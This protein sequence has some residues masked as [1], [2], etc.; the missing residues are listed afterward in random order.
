M[1][2][3]AAEPVIADV[4]M[5]DVEVAE[6]APA[7]EEEAEPK[8]A[9]RSRAKKE[10]PAKAP[11]KPDSEQRP[12]R[13]RKSVELFKPP[14][15][16]PSVKKVVVKEVGAPCCAPHS[17]CARRAPCQQ[18]LQCF[19][20]ANLCL[21][22]PWRCLLL[23]LAQLNNARLNNTTWHVPL[24]CLTSMPSRACLY[25]QGKGTKLGEITNGEGPWQAVHCPRQARVLCRDK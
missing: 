1:A 19:S 22:H 20:A 25:T 10:T 18:C 12:K 24:H 7:K 4:P 14:V 15:A 9:S 11:A 5:A 2:T 17:R 6:P 13:E 23:G 8:S 3:E 16:P 21:A